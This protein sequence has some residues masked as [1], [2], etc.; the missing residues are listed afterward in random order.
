M[1]YIK[2]NCSSKADSVCK[3]SVYFSY[4]TFVFSSTCISPLPLNSHLCISNAVVILY[5]LSETHRVSQGNDNVSTHIRF[6]TQAFG[7]VY[8]GLQHCMVVIV[9]A[10]C[11]NFK[12]QAF[13]VVFPCGILPNSSAATVSYEILA[14]I[15]VGKII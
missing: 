6:P 9:E 15:L 8:H 7:T 14:R 11:G 4:H 3:E 10:P 1:F 2:N 12:L 13:G 5:F